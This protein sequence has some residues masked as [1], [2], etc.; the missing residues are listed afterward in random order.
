METTISQ[1]SGYRMIVSG[2][3]PKLST[4]YIKSQ[5]VNEE[6]WPD[7]F[8]NM[9]KERLKAAVLKHLSGLGANV[10]NQV[11]NKFEITDEVV[12]ACRRKY[13]AF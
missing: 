11:M 13:P 10:S 5:V 3:I 9:A 12:A 2:K 6:V 7:L 8:T 1:Y 4:S